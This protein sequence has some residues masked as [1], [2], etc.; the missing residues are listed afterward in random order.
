MILI[1]ASSL[2][3]DRSTRH[4]TSHLLPL[5]F[6]ARLK[7]HLPTHLPHPLSHEA[8]SEAEL[9]LR[10]WSLSPVGESWKGVEEKPW[11]GGIRREQSVQEKEMDE[12]DGEWCWREAWELMR[13][14]TQSYSVSPAWL[15]L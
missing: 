6:P 10:S 1:H 11:T 9:E 2:E 14:M 3:A 12:N 4:L 7:H 15:R 8:I 13:V 5:L